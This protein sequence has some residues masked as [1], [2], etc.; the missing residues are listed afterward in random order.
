MKEL[1]NEIYP[2]TKLQLVDYVLNLH[3]TV[4]LSGQAPGFC[5]TGRKISYK[6]T[7]IFFYILLHAIH[8]LE[9]TTRQST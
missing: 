4:Q 2:K 3:Q 6:Y 1:K 5:M 9:Y 7:S 8:T